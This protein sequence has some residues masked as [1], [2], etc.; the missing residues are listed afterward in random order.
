[1]SFYYNILSKNAVL[2][3][4]FIIFGRIKMKTLISITTPSDT[5]TT[6]WLLQGWCV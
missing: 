5:T 2:N 1:M 3:N 4:Y 6:A